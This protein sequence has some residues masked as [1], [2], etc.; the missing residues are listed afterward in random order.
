MNPLPPSYYQNDDVVFL[1]KDLLGKKL[2][3]NIN[4]QF[5]SGIITETEAYCGR[6]DKACHANNGKRTKRTEVMFQ[7]GG[8]AYV[9]LCYGIHNLFNVT[10][11]VN[12]LADAI[13]VRAIQPVDGIEIML[14]RRNKSKLDKTLSSGPGTLSQ[15]LGIDRNF[16]G[17]DLTGPD[18]W[19][20][21]STTK[22]A[23]SEIVAS[24][25]IGVDYAREDAL[26]PWRFYIKNSIW[27][28]KL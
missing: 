2:C 28:S 26:R 3:T 15:A 24:T 1:A 7:E 20:E 23:H 4:G 5:T 19:I 14:E 17:L 25:R 10:S 6:N 13:L 18:I 22:I 16:Y 27:V 9:Y 12:G 21:N 8:K 11:N